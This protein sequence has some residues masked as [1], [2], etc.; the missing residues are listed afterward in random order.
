MAGYGGFCVQSKFTFI[1]DYVIISE[2]SIKFAFLRV[3]YEMR[4]T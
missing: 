3:F 4:F 1:C 2:W